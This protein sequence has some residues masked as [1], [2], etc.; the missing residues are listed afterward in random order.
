[1]QLEDGMLRIKRSGES[2][3]EVSD[4]VQQSTT[5]VRQ[6]SA[7]VRQQNEG[8]TQIFT[9]IRHLSGI[10]EETVSRHDST[11][12]ASLMLKAVSD[13]VTRLGHAYEHRQR[14]E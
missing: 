5:S 13:E 4:M 2:F 8:M 6:I 10:M 11:Q 1:M 3:R 12:Q 7:P 14:V 9:A